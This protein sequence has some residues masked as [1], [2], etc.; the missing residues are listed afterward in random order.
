MDVMVARMVSF[1]REVRTGR[2]HSMGMTG[3]SE[4][5]LIK[6]YVIRTCGI[7]VE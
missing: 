5:P 4:V 7:L 2:V 1:S 3:D 6:S